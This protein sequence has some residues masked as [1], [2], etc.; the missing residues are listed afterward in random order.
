MLGHFIKKELME[1]MLNVRF[2]LI[3]VL[4]TSL[5]TVSSVL[6]IKRYK[7]ELTEYHRCIFENQNKLETK[8]DR[9]VNLLDTPQILM[10]PPHPLRFV[11]DG[12]E[13]EL[14]N[15]VQL[16]ILDL[17]EIENIGFHN[18]FIPEAGGL[19]DLFIIQVVLS[20]LA[21]LLTF[22]AVCGEKE[23]GTLR[24]SLSNPVSRD[25]I[26][27]GKYMSCM[28]IMIFPLLIGF[29]IQLL[30]L[31]LSPSIMLTLAQTIKVL[32]IGLVSML[33]LSLFILLGI[34]V[35]SRVSHTT[36]SLVLLLL[37]WVIFV[38]VIP[39]YGASILSSKMVSFPTQAEIEKEVERASDP[40]W[41]QYPEE[42]RWN[43][44]VGDPRNVRHVKVAMEAH[45]A[46]EKIREA[47]RRKKIQTV[48]WTRRLTKISPAAIYQH[49]SESVA[50][51]GLDHIKHFLKWAEIYRKDMERFFQ[52][53]DARD[54]ESQH[55]YYHPD[56]VSHRLFDPEDVP[57]FRVPPM[58]LGQGLQFALFDILILVLFNVIFFYM[59]YV[60][61]IRYD[62]R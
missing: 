42:F 28:V 47:Y 1:H 20:F 31:F 61:F 4:I 37:I 44:A 13:T 27:F 11:A 10:I 6:F 34:T 17:R 54:P 50:G 39:D 49:V 32:V 22:N 35:S 23:I 38:V 45:E 24:L 53:E 52:I 21:I 2:L 46:G 58:A 55:L 3:F 60:S 59:A 43:Y 62:V 33:Y 5:M 7:N 12:Q 26:L 8:S 9:L 41:D 18:Q 36:V 25:T 51:T 29:I 57:Q 15:S 14:P 19:D 48:E 16:S 56:Y 30:L 40:V